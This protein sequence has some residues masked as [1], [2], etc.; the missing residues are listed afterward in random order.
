MT[1]RMRTK[2]QRWWSK[3]ELKNG[4]APSYQKAQWLVEREFSNQ[5]GARWLAGTL[6]CAAL[7][8]KWTSLCFPSVSSEKRSSS[9]DMV[10]YV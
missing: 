6:P 5:E 1:D 8:V 2:K 7:S 9:G 10:K 4:K 3:K